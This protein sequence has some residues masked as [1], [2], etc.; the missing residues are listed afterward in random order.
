MSWTVDTAKRF[1]QRESRVN[2]IALHSAFDK[3][4]EGEKHEL[5]SSLR[6][7]SEALDD[8]RRDAKVNSRT[9]RQAIQRGG[10]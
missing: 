5:V 8:A 2:P 10:M 4:N 1:L 6:Q 3:L 9:I 7:I